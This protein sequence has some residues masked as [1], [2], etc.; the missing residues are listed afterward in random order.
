MICDKKLHQ[1][2][3]S[4]DYLCVFVIHLNELPPSVKRQTTMDNLLLKDRKRKLENGNSQRTKQHICKPHKPTHDQS[5]QKSC[6][7][8]DTP[9]PDSAIARNMD[10]RI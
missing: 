10:L 7:L 9:L 3:P 1:A 8:S 6:F 4:I 2:N 5:L